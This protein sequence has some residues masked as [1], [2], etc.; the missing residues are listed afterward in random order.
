MKKR[1]AKWEK[2]RSKGKWHYIFKYGV[3][4]V[5]LITTVLYS[6]FFSMLL[7]EMLYFREF[8]IAIVVF[9]LGGIG[10]GLLMWYYM[11]NSYSKQKTAD[12]V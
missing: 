3:F 11:E 2:I 8:L 4:I 10:W 6:L 12:S 5:G 7:E 1:F 9:T